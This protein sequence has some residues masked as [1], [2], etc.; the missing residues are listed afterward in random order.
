[1]TYLPQMWT[2]E[3]TITPVGVAIITVPTPE[4]VRDELELGTAATED[5]ED[6]R[7][8]DAWTTFSL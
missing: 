4:E 8:Q 5:I 6:I 3:T 7:L 1:M 2:L